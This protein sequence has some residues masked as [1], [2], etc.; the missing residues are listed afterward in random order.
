MQ[1]YCTV[2]GRPLELVEADPVEKI[3]WFTCPL[4]TEDRAEEAQGH[5]ALSAPLDE[6][7]SE[8]QV[9]RED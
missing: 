8:E 9:E 4:Y 2:C 1:R 6:G 5:T 3:G 7:V